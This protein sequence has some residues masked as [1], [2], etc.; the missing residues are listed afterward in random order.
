MTAELARRIRRI[1]G[2]SISIPIGVSIGGVA[3]G[4]HETH[5]EHDQTDKQILFDGHDS[6]NIT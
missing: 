1:K 2:V 6:E 3:T 5:G 4:S